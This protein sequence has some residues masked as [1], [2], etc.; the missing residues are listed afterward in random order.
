MDDLI[1][2]ENVKI[3]LVRMYIVYLRIIICLSFIIQRFM[4]VYLNVAHLLLIVDGSKNK[5]LVHPKRV[6][7]ISWSWHT[8]VMLSHVHI[9]CVLC[10][11]QNDLN[12]VDI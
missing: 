8:L 7:V 2:P 10:I 6:Q 9:T 12:Y 5:L 4:D 1:N 3:F 11:C